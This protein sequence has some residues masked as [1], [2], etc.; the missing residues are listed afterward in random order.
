MD[1][2]LTRRPGEE[3]DF[4]VERQFIRL[5]ESEYFEW[6]NLK[7]KLQRI[8]ER[9]DKMTTLAEELGIEETT[10][11]EVIPQLATELTDLQTKLTEK[12]ATLNT[13]A[14]T[15]AADSAELA[16]NK[17]EL[18]AIQVVKEGLTPIVE[19]AKGLVPAPVGTPAEQPV[20]TQPEVPVTP[21]TEPPV[22]G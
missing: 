13:Q 11:S 7:L 17:A 2:S 20:E 16:T 12:E 15:L 14:T 18:A 21:P 10:L 22:A 5:N 19:K 4:Y 9:L 6:N 3:F 8:E 1:K